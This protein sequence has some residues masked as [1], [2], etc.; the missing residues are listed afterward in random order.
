MLSS[1]ANS[2]DSKAR[3]DFAIRLQDYS[4]YSAHR[5]M[6]DFVWDRAKSMRFFLLQTDRCERLASP[7]LS[8]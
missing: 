8:S 6:M 1:L 2:F 7:F 3:S 5:N 4:K